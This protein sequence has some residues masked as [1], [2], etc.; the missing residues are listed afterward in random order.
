MVDDLIRIDPLELPIIRNHQVAI[1]NMH[2]ALGI[3]NAEAARRI[4]KQTIQKFGADKDIMR[5][6]ELALQTMPPQT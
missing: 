1:K 4:N 3:T 5:F 2:D 6:T